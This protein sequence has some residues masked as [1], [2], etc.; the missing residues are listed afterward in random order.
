MKLEEAIKLLKKQKCVNSAYLYDSY[1]KSLQSSH[2]IDILL[3]VDDSAD[4]KT[5]KKIAK[6]MKKLSNKIELTTAT[7]SEARNYVHQSLSSFYYVNLYNCSKHLMG[8][9]AITTPPSPNLK[10]LSRRV[11]FTTQRLR[12]AIV[13]EDK[14]DIS[15]FVYKLDKWIPYFVQETMYVV[16][17][18]Y[19]PVPKDALK[20]L[21][22]N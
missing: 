2:D 3:V 21:E 12:N 7:Q 15:Y 4:L 13:D 20:A 18:E 6:K 17:N 9:E 11:A 1:L 10:E 19:I 5:L 8:K 22:K 16:Y 14:S